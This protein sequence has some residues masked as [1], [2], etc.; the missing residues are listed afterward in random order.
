MLVNA[1]V[2]SCGAPTG[3]AATADFLRLPDR[4]TKPRTAGITHVLDKGVPPMLLRAHLEQTGDLVDFVKLGWGTG[5][6]DPTLDERIRI[7]RAHHVRLCTGGT[8][9]EIVTAQGRVAQFARWARRM[10]IEAVEVSNGLGLLDRPAKHRLIRSLAGEF[11]VL[12]ETGLKDPTA[13]VEPA[14]WAQEMSADLAAGASLV[15]AE[16]RESGTVGLFEPDGRVRDALVETIVAEVPVDRIV[17]EA[18][19]KS[20]QAW[21]VNRLGPGVNLGNIDLADVL[22]A[23][24]LRLG[25]RADTAA[26]TTGPTPW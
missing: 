24:T 10:G 12:A 11:V 3:A 15:V 4:S 19:Q 9:L 14:R 2:A 1:A 18:P 16:G 26:S 23:E 13:H 25:L 8:L 6:V 21:L 22:P 20:Q 7:C 17:F 5:Y